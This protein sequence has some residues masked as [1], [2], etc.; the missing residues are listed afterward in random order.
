MMILSSGLKQS[1]ITNDAKQMMGIFVL[2]KVHNTSTTTTHSHISI[3][4]TPLLV[5]TFL[6]NCMVTWQLLIVFLCKF[7]S[8]QFFLP[9]VIILFQ[10]RGMPLQQ[11]RRKRSCLESS[12]MKERE[13]QR[14]SRKA[15]RRF[16][17]FTSRYTLFE[18]KYQH[19][20]N[21]SWAG[22]EFPMR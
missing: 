8:Q 1:I 12:M 18:E 5:V 9:F 22:A 7:L 10:L 6:N 15:T 17:S 2:G 21:R 13:T 11:K 20:H 14:N 19:Q 16:P 3:M 4:K